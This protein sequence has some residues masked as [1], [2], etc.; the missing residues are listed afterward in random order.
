M[1]RLEI[2]AEVVAQCHKNRMKH[3]GSEHDDT[4]TGNDWIAFITK[5]AGRAVLSKWD[6]AVY[7]GHMIKAAAAAFAA[8]EWCDRQTGVSE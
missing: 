8:I 1:S 3:G 2:A 5:H 7:R 6:I 4:H